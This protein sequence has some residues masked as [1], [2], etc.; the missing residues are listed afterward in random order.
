VAIG[1]VPGSRPPGKPG[2]SQCR[3]LHTRNPGADVVKIT[4]AK[5][6]GFCFG[7]KRA[8]R[9]ALQA[10]ASG[11]PVEVLGDIVHNEV[12]VQQ[13]QA[14]GIKKIHAPGRGNGKI[15]LIRAHGAPRHLTQAARDSGY[16]IID[17]TC[18]MVREIHAIAR[19]M[20]DNGRA[21]IIIGDR[22]HEEVLGIAGQLLRQPI[23]I[24]CPDAIDTSQLRAIERAG[25]VVQSTQTLENV[26]MIVAALRR[27]I[28]D[29]AVHNTICRATSQRQADL[30]TLPLENDVVLV[31]GSKSSANTKRL[32]EISKSRNP[33]TYWIAT[34]ADINPAWFNGVSTVGITA[35]ASTPEES[36]REIM[37]C[38]EAL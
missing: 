20:E 32:Y 13:M 37:G 18:P 36:I 12:V 21:V 33:A 24:D 19:D 26:T 31:I 5:S 16:T 38:L 14:A 34:R 2:V 10:A 23:I 11:S 27:H 28:P 30:A 8:I 1:L 7:V 25:V 6:A 3:Q 9:M 29:L 17:A 22:D 35:G 4:V 15:L